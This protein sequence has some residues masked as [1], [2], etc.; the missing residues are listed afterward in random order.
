MKVKAKGSQNP[1]KKE[2]KKRQRNE[3]DA[4]KRR[5]KRRGKRKGKR[6]K[7]YLYYFYLNRRYHG[8]FCK[9]MQNAHDICDFKVNPKKKNDSA[10]KNEANRVAQPEVNGETGCRIKKSSRNLQY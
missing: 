1:T 4:K 6:R 9:K 2:R 5:G 3:T 10:Q 7:R 8:G